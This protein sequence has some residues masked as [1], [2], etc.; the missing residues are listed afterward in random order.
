MDDSYG[1]FKRDI[2]YVGIL[3]GEDLHDGSLFQPED[4]GFVEGYE[5]FAPGMGNRVNLFVQNRIDYIADDPPQFGLIIQWAFRGSSRQ[6]TN[7]RAGNTGNTVWQT[8]FY[9]ELQS[10]NFSEMFLMSEDAS[11]AN[12]YVRAE[13]ANYNFIS[14]PNKLDNSL[15]EGFFASFYGRNFT[16]IPITAKADYMTVYFYSRPLDYEYDESDYMRVWASVGHDAV[17]A[18]HGLGFK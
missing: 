2:F 13:N 11:P 18:F 5:F 14:I 6:V 1:G 12:P 7:A 3:S 10:F 15:V 17:G 9:G 4:R 8:S 16:V